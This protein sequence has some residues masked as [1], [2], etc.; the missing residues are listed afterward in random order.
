[1][2]Q[3]ATFITLEG[4]DGSG[5]STIIK[6]L[7]KL[8]KSEKANYLITREPGGSAFGNKLRKLILSSSHIKHPLT[9]PLLFY[10]ARAEHIEMTIKPALSQGTMVICDR[11]HDASHAYQAVHHNLDK[12]LKTLD[13]WI[14]ADIQPDLTLFLDAP[15][16][17]CFKR[18][19]K[20]RK[21][22]TFDQ[23]D[24]TFYESVRSRYLA[25]A[26][27]DPERIKIIDASQSIAQVCHACYHAIQPWL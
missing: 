4:I 9:H 7:S 18:I 23:Q 15:V 26:H 10:A 12:H 24:K 5:K 6:H 20:R 3:K 13:Q 22:D 25:R 21:L 19:A 8:L 1:M 17:L 2:K 16:E 14:V 27:N 11:F